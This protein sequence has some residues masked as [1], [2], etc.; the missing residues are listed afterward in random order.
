MAKIGPCKCCFGKVSNEA[1]SC[2]HCGQPNPYSKS[3]H[4][5]QLYEIIQNRG[6]IGAIQKHREQTKC[7]LEEAKNYVDSLA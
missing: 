5:E 3:S 2:P 1:I 6:K 4:D 7:S